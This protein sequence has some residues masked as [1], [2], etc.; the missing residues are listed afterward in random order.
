MTW[1]GWPVRRFGERDAGPGWAQ[2]VPGGLDEE[3][4]GVAGAGLGD[5]ALA[6]ALAGLVERRARGRARR[7][8]APAAGSGRSRRSRG[9]ARTRSAC[10]CRGS[11][12]S[13]ATVCDQ[14]PSSASRESRSSS[15]VL[16]ATRPSTAASVVEVGEL[17][18]GLVE[19]LPLEPAA[20][21]LRPAR[22]VVDTAVQQQ[23]LRDTVAAAHQV[24]ANLLTRPREVT[25][26]LERSA[27]APLTAFSWPASRSRA[28]SS[29]SLRSLLIRSPGGPRRLRSARSPRPASPGRLASP[30]ERKPGRARLIT[31]AQRLRQPRQ[32]TPSPPRCRHQN[33]HAAS[34]PVA[35]SIAAACVE[36]AWTSRPTYVIVTV[37]VGPSFGYMGSAGARLRPDKPPICNRGSGP[38][39]TAANNRNRV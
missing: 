3:P 2:V 14:S 25:G 6:A 29:A 35:T 39:R 21:R 7:R 22:P 20:V 38:H 11:S 33:E 19:P 4:A 12:A 9:R 16:R 15:A 36:R 13:R 23:Q 17:G 8:A 32:A 5:R 27:A 1:S 10:R 18:R 30:V 24:A 34:S 26:R 28:S 37:T 31:A